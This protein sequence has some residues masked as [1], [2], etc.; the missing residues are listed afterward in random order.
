M[1]L[2]QLKATAEE[3][4]ALQEAIKPLEARAKDLK[5]Q[6]KKEL[7][8]GSYAFGSAGIEIKELASER[9]NKE[10]MC[11]F[12]QCKLEDLAPFMK[13]TVCQQVWVRRVTNL[14]DK[15]A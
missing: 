11:T 10:A 13:Q 5:E 12:F 15:A 1:D 7:P 2:I 3:L 6:L 14:E 8:L 9:L 4:L